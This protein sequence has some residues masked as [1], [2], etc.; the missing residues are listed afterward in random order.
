MAKLSL[1]ARIKQFFMGKKATP[2]A[3]AQVKDGIW[4]AT[5]EHGVYLVGL[6]ESL[7]DQI[8]KITYA[9]FPTKNTDLHVNDDILDIEG[10]KSVET[11]QS[12]IAGTI[13]E[14]N[15]HL[16]DDIEQLNQPNPKVNWIMKVKP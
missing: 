12:P 15:S 13:I 2:Y 6:A 8:G 11:L 5:D 4:Y 14:R 3:D 16:G 1:W 7:Y 10:D 9:D